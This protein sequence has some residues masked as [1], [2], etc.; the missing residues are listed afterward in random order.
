MENMEQAKK[1]IIDKFENNAE[2]KKSV[3]VLQEIIEQGICEE[4]RYQVTNTVTQWSVAEN[5]SYPSKCGA[6]KSTAITQS[7]Q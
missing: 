3:D 5:T 7:L 4:Q 6:L 2:V 1:N